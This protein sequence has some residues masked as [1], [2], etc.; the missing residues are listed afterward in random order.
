MVGNATSEGL[1]LADNE[2][3]SPA[4]LKGWLD[5]LQSILPFRVTV[6]VESDYSGIFLSE[7]MNPAYERYIVSSTDSTNNTFRQGGLTFGNWFWGEIR[8][9]KSIQRAFANSVAFARASRIQPIAFSLDDDG[10]GIYEKK[11][12]GLRTSD[13]FIGTLFLTGDNEVQIGH[14]RESLVLEPEGSGVLFIDDAF[15]PDG[16]DLEVTATLVNADTGKILSDEALIMEDS[17]PGYYQREIRFDEFPGRRTLC[18][19][20]SSRIN[21]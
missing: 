14:A 6:V 4:E 11:K 12:D 3:L 18:S 9:G 2:I 15:S 8:R 5:T 20:N 17:G 21:E 13:K 19:C 1:V 16:A 7:L 10:N